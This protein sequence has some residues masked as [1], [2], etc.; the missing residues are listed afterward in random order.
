MND[1]AAGTAAPVE[2]VLELN[3]I[4]GAAVPGL[5]K[6]HQ[7]LIGINCS[8]TFDGVK[9]FKTFIRSMSDQVAK[10]NRDAS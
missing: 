5:L 4:Q 9:K 3:D 1:V 10:G 6:P 2:P 8:A 7:T